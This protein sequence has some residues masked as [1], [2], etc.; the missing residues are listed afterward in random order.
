MIDM[1]N[2][3]A[4]SMGEIDQVGRKLKSRE[5]D[6]EVWCA[7]RHA[8][9]EDMERKAEAADAAKHLLTAGTFYLH[10]GVYYFTGSDLSRRVSASSQVTAAACAASRKGRFPRFYFNE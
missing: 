4:S 5:S 8:M 10:A 6:A 9:G 3:G 7:E 2:W 1:A